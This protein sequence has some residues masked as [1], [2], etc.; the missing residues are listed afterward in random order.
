MVVES[1][2]FITKKQ[3]NNL[4]CFFVWSFA[5]QDLLRVNTTNKA[6]TFTMNGVN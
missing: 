5:Y 6:V 1:V 2:N 3:V 4:T